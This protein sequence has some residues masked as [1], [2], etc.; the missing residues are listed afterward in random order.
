MTWHVA[1]HLLLTK[2]A[3]ISAVPVDVSDYLTYRRHRF[4]LVRCPV[5]IQLAHVPDNS[6]VS[7]CVAAFRYH[8]MAQG[9]RLTTP[10]LFLLTQPCSVACHST[11]IRPLTYE[12]PICLICASKCSHQVIGKQRS[13]ETTCLYA[14]FHVPFYS[15]N[16]FLVRCCRV[17]NVVSSHFAHPSISFW[18]ITVDYL[19]CF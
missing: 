8:S 10:L 3:H 12:R 17:I 13:Q 15:W 14:I 18:F 6:A 7:N 16:H 1:F 2:E 9:G 5:T 4:R 11:P 19:H